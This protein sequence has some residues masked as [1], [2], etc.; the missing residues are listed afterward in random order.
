MTA[1]VRTDLYPTRITG[2]SVPQSRIDP[3]VWG[4]ALSPLDKEQL[5]HYESNG[6]LVLD[7]LLSDEEVQTYL[8]EVKRL[9]EDPAVRASERAVLEPD[10]NQMRSLFEV[11]KVSELFAELLH[12]P[13]LT[14]IAR[15][16]LGSEVYIHQSRVNYKPG[17][18]GAPFHW[19]SDF[20]TW[21]SEDGMPQPRAF[22]L[23]ISLTANFPFNGPL[24]VIPG[25]HKLFFPT[26]GE[27][28]PDYHKESLQVASPSVGSPDHRHLTRMADEH[29]IAQITGD[30]GSAVM[31]DSNMLHGSNG[32]LSPFARSNIFIVYN[33]VENTLE[34]PFAAVKP[35]PQHISNREFPSVSST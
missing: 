27:T 17:F 11:E 24:M 16:V 2:E 29:G 19:H 4:E 10:S 7:E 21:H 18:G 28:P 9:S 20:E 31:F 26:I 6:Y 32:N 23:S 15:Q 34:A 3:T 13:R 8:A 5:D 33:S 12:S 30:A 14:D 25:S 22:S 35:R 1:T